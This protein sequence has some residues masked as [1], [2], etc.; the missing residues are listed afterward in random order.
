REVRVLVGN[1]EVFRGVPFKLGINEQGDQ[2]ITAYDYNVYLSKSSDHLK[3]ANKKASDIIR[4]ICT[5]YGIKTGHIDDTKYVIPRL[6][7]KGKTLYDMVVVALTETRKRT[8][9]R[10]FLRNAKGALELREVKSQTKFLHIEAG[11]NLMSANFTEDIEERK[12]QVKLT[13]GDESSP[14]EVVVKSND[15][16]RDYGIMQHYEH[17]SEVKATNKLKPLA[18]ALLK[19]LNK[20]EQEFDIEALGDVAMVSGVQIKVT[21]PMTGLSGAFYISADSHKFSAEGL[22]TMSLKLRRELELPEQEYEKPEEQAKPAKTKED[23][24]AGS[25][26]G[27]S[28]G[29]SSSA[30]VRLANSYK[31]RLSYKYGGKNV[32]GGSADCSG[33]TYYVFKKAAGINIG[34]GTSTQAKKGRKVSKADAQ[35]G[36]LVFFQGTYRKG[37]SHVGI[38]TRP[39]YCVS[40]A[41]SGC[42][43]HS[44]VSGYWGKHF[45]QIRR[46]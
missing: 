7:F 39:G 33:F 35:P 18:D 28:S 31:G 19:E 5:K 40:L 27:G 34:H 26:S 41:S 38:V 30:V 6:I 44:Y 13:G 11:R 21:E 22:H 12:T 4:S 2:S 29:D 14:V 23:V 10:Y 42:E 45:M 1:E 43:E 46:V 32:E 37:V 24:R 9:K 8:G 36:D 20:T 17:N 3:F 15:A 25:T 16:I